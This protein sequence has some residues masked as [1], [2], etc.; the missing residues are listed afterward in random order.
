M[1]EIEADRRGPVREPRREEAAG[2]RGSLVL[3]FPERRGNRLGW[4]VCELDGWLYPPPR[5]A[6]GLCFDCEAWLWVAA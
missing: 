2:E 1:D 6:S 5:R 3:A 4:P